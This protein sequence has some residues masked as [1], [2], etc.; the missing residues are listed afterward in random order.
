MIERYPITDRESWL[1]MRRQD[2]TASDIGA[3]AG[4]D[5][6]R[7][8]LSVFTDKLGLGVTFQTAL[9]QRGIWLEAA[10][11]EAMVDTLPNWKIINPKIYLRDPEIRL[12]CTPDRLAED[13]DIGGLI[14]CQ[15]KS[16]SKP[17]F[18][19]WNGVVPL[20]YT[21]QTAC[22]G[23]MLNARTSYLVAFVIATYTAELHLFEVPRHAGAETR[24]RQTAVD[25]WHDMDA[26][27][28]PK[29]DFYRDAEVIAALYQQPKAGAHV[30][31]STSNRAGAILA[32]RAERKARIKEDSTEVEALDTEL[33]TMIGD[34]ETAELPGWKISWKQ[35]SRK[36]YTVPESVT[37]V[38]RVTEQEEEA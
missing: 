2:L 10:A 21:L 19:K 5:P 34:A 3:V 7:T 22:E 20:H 32:E 11:H 9:M 29:P 28:M 35:Q 38:L 27:Q 14:N 16:V 8:A 30:D 23:M 13:E 24:I 33:K 4:V 36:A 37:R 1:A 15:I 26:G 12:G 18:E 31:L 17:T 6:Y 25:F